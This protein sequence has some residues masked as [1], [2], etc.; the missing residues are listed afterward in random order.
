M[1]GRDYQ[2]QNCSAA[3][4]L[5]V[6]GERWSLLIVRDIGFA[7]IHRFNDLQRNLGVARNVLASRL[8]HLVAAG[9]LD[10]EEAGDLLYPTYTLTEKGKGLLG[11]ITAMTQWGD[12]WHAP[13]GPPVTFHHDGCP[14]EVRHELI[15]TECGRAITSSVLNVR[16]GPGFARDG[17]PDRA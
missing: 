3:R 11:V 12:E 17:S 8:D 14:G 2:N 6:I 9:V 5:E 7:G 4:A 10:R 16:P 1:L 13:A 15:C